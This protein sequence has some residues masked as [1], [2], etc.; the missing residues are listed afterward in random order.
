MVTDKKLLKQFWLLSLSSLLFFS[1]FSIMMMELPEYLASLGGA[2][3]KGLIIGLF[4]LT[5]GFSRPFSGK[6]SDKIGRIPVMVFGTI[7]CIVSGFFYPLM[8]SLFGFLFLRFVH[9]LSTGFKPTAT[10]AY[11]ADIISPHRRGEAMGI[12]GMSA[13]LG[14]SLGPILGSYLVRTYSYDVMFY[15]SS[16]LA[17]LSVIILLGM[18]ETVEQK[19]KFRLKMLLLKKNEI[20]ETA[21]MPAA[22]LMFLSIFTYGV[23][24]TNMP[25]FGKLFGVENNGV[26]LTILTIGAFMTRFFSGKA[27]DKYGRI[28]VLKV[29]ISIL[30]LA[31]IGISFTM[32]I[33]MFYATAA[34]LGVAMGSINP[35]L[36]ALTIDLT[37]RDARGKGVASL[38]IAMELGIGIGAL[39]A[40]YFFGEGEELLRTSFQFCA[41]LGVLALVYLFALPQSHRNESLKE[42]QNKGTV[43]ITPEG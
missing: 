26:F 31:V 12:L 4:T 7:I 20:F 17:F 41:L 24:L 32:N 33:T 42:I 35:T 23:V 38:Y 43:S 1:S 21:I 3:H 8:T 37:P 28:V 29:G 10:A 18:K 13:A 15:A 9:G 16:M 6:L 34:L 19:E 39:I 22:I 11:V 30:V 5:A 14:L 27:S 40:G 25:A 2:E 36:F